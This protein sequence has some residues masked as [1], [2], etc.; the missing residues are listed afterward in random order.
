MA[1]TKRS[2]RS[3]DVGE[4]GRIR[5]RI[6]PDPKTGLFQVEWRENGRRRSR[7]LGHRDWM[8]AKRQADKVAVGLAESATTD[9]AEAEPEPLTL[10]TLFDIYRE[11]V[12]PTKAKRSRRYERTTM[13][14]FLK[15]FGRAQ[16]P[17]T[18]SQRD[19]DR[20]IRARRAGRIGPSG[21]PV[22]NRTIEYD[23]K[24]LLAVL[25][26]ARPRTKSPSR[27]AAWPPRDERLP[28]P[29]VA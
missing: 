18:L 21:K 26:W 28:P 22:S 5:V 24:F 7:S 10:E 2:R 6:F 8:R 29:P 23:L 15:F 19:W 25:N 14:M 11:E 9:T 3:Y 4:W 17:A 27:C 13:A 16:G 20:F 12:T 1:R